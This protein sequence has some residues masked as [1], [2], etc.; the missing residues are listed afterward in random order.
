MSR[1]IGDTNDHLMCRFSDLYNNI[2]I[3]PSGC[4]IWRRSLD[5][6]GY[7]LIHFPYKLWRGHRL[8]YSLFKGE[9]IKKLV[10]H[11]ICENKSCI[12]PLHLAQISVR[13][14][15]ILGIN[16]RLERING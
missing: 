5:K 16:S 8:I 1:Q 10:I 4:H 9:L 7:A 15:T 2:E 6:D 11:H 13:R 12:N 14:N 3:T